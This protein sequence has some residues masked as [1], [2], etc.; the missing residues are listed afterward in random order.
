MSMRCEVQVRG[1]GG[2][3]GTGITALGNS[4]RRR[5]PPIGGEG[6]RGENPWAEDKSIFLIKGVFFMFRP[7]E[8]RPVDACPI[9]TLFG[10][11]APSWG[12]NPRA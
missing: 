2:Q 11:L 1:G 12:R 8:F 5:S 10:N 9:L 3:R 6:L 4:P 7:R